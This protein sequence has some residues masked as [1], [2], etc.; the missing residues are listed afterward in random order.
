MPR[1]PSDE[2]SCAGIAAFL[3]SS[4]EKARPPRFDTTDRRASKKLRARARNRLCQPI[5]GRRP[6][7]STKGGGQTP[8]GA[9]YPVVYWA[10]MATLVAWTAYS[11]YSAIVGL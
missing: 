5:T 1:S 6:R 3:S 8:G 7:R 4:H 9:M 2:L 10:G 11:A